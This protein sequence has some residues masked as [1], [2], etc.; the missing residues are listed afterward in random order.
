[1]RLDSLYKKRNALTVIVS[2]LGPKHCATF[3]ANDSQY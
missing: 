3:K 1:M 2:P